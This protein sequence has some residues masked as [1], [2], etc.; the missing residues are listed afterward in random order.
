MLNKQSVNAY[1][2]S[3]TISGNSEL[4]KR[5]KEELARHYWS[6]VERLEHACLILT[7]NVEHR[8]LIIEWTKVFKKARV[9]SDQATMILINQLVSTGMSPMAAAILVAKLMELNIKEEDKKA[10]AHQWQQA[11]PFEGGMTAFEAL[12]HI[13]NQITPSLS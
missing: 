6:T 3:V 5:F 7:T 13:I 1:L 8:Q 4:D 2:K 12:I 9:T 11:I 10:V